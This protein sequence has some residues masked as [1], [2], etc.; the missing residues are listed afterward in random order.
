MTFD[1]VK[2]MDVKGQIEWLRVHGVNLPPENGTPEEVLQRCASVFLNKKHPSELPVA[3]PDIK[4][5]EAVLPAVNAEKM[6]KPSKYV[7][8]RVKAQ[9]QA[10]PKAALPKGQDFPRCGYCSKALT[11]KTQI[12]GES[13]TGQKMCT[14]CAAKFPSKLKTKEGT[15]MP[16]AKSYKKEVKAGTKKT[17]K[18]TVSTKTGRKGNADALKKANAAMPKDEAGFRIGSKTQKIFALLHKG[19]TGETLK[20]IRPN[21]IGLIGAFQKKA[22]E[23]SAGREAVIKEDG[24]KYFLKSFKTPDGKTV[25]VKG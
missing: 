10:E 21:A 17:T 14:E 7:A 23:T 16:K 13:T 8:K 4:P 24:D 12:G 25:Y 11:D 2:K 1:E 6:A 18:K 15:E 19:A 9:A 3:V 20:K 5:S 22:S